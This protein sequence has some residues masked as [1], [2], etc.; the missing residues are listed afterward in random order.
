MSVEGQGGFV[1]W[2]IYICNEG[3][4]FVGRKEDFYRFFVFVVLRCKKLYYF[5]GY[6]RL[7]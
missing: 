6:R 5:L 1:L 3:E 2:L 4:F 7:I